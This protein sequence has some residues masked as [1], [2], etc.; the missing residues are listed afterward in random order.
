VVRV[1][2][3]KYGVGNIYS[4]VSALRRVGAEAYV[5]LSVSEALKADA[6]VLPGVGTYSAAMRRVGGA[7]HQLV[8]AVEEGTPI[9]GICLGMQLFFEESEEGG[10]GLSLLP[11]RVVRLKASKLPHMGWSLVRVKASSLLLEGVG[12]GAYFYFMHSY[13]LTNTASPWVKAV[14]VH[15]QE[16]AAVVEKPPL[17]GTQFHPERSG[18]RGLTV[19]SNF[20]REVRR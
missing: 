20:I 4:V 7:R 5:A 15:G 12:D 19:L 11:G 14:A 16:F 2:V 18:R 6:I 10:R 17:Y 8:E 9:L 3:L 13:A 1:A